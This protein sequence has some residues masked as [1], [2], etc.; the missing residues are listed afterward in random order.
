MGAGRADMFLL[1]SKAD[2]DSRFTRIM[3][4][5]RLREDDEDLI[6]AVFVAFF[7]VREKISGCVNLVSRA[8]F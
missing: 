6:N 3:V 5:K 7:D 4:N 2:S 8:P 1:T